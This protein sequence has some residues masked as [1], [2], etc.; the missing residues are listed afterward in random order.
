MGKVLFEKPFD[1][2]ESRPR[3]EG[4]QY[5]SR[6][7]ERSDCSDLLKVYSDVNAVPFFNSDNCCGDNFYYQTDKE[8]MNAIDFWIEKFRN[9]EFMR[10][11]VVDNTSHTAI[12]TIELFKRN[13]DDAFGNCGVLRLDLRSDYEK[14][15][16]IIKI[17]RPIVFRA[18]KLFDCDE[19]ITKAV[20][21]ATERIGALKSFG[22]E[23]SDKKLIGHDGTEYGDYYAYRIAVPIWENPPPILKTDEEYFYNLINNKLHFFPSSYSEDSHLPFSLNCPFTVYDISGMTDKQI[24]LLC[25]LAP[26]AIVDCLHNGNKVWYCDWNHNLFLYDPRNPENCQGQQGE[27]ISFTDEGIAY[28]GDFFPNGDYFFHIEKDGNFGLFS[29]PWREEIWIYGKDL[30]KEF[31]TVYKQVGFVP[32][33]V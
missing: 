21:D 17:L 9:K 23:A 31:E 13:S 32:K 10:F 25:E 19:Y 6:L 30:L 18:F 7:V 20:P 16:E 33:T 14:E 24:I 28:F 11:A 5:T 4:L 12:G 8:M 2:Y 15:T 29:H 3:Y 27:Y 1:A 22:F 26:K